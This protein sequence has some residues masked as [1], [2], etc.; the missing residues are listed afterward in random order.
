VSVPRPLRAGTLAAPGYE[1][2]D[3]LHRSNGFDVY[4]VWSQERRTRAVAKLPRPDRL[5]DVTLRRR[6]EQEGRLLRRLTHPHIVR[7][8][9]FIAG[10]PPVVV[11]ETLGGQT[12]AHLIETT[13]RLAAAEAAVLGAQLSS[14]LSYLHGCG[15]L[16][17]DLKPSNIVVERG[18][19]VIVDLSIARRPGRARP[20]LG[21]WCYLAPEQAFGR[22][23]SPATDVWGLGVVLFEALSGALAFGADGP[24]SDE[25]ESYPQLE[26]PAPRLSSLRRL[27]AGLAGLVDACLESDPSR[28]PSL[29]VLAAELE[30]VPGAGSPRAARTAT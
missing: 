7:G 16:H 27:P 28:R 26:G 17:L 3:H 29:A 23:L 5:E 8:Y 21:T 10:P 18:R 1:V 14:A 12:L 4:D 6:L 20:G 19:A 25:G 24:S 30:R 2:L 15:Y 22:P 13:G 11:T 9:A